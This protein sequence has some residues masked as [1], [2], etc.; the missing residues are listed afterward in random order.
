MKE[1]VEFRIKEE[2]VGLLFTE[3]EGKKLGYDGNIRKIVIDTNDPRFSQIGV[4]QARFKS[5]KFSFFSK[6]RFFFAGWHF[7]RKYSKV[8]LDKATMFR[9]LMTK[10]FEPSGEEC[11][12]IFDES[13]T[14]SICG[15][16]TTQI[17]PLQLRKNS[18]PKSKDFAFTIAINELVISKRAAEL[19]KKNKVTGVTI[20]PILT[21]KRSNEPSSEWFQ[22]IVNN[23]SLESSASTRFGLNP[24]DEDEKGEYRCANG[25]KLGLNILSELR[26]K[27]DSVADFDFVST[28]Q[29]V[30]QRGQGLFRPHRLILVSQKVR[31]II[32]ENNLKG[33]RLE[34]A[35]LE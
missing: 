26:V 16:G 25:H 28:R 35:Y 14:C 1:T 19:F 30:G 18:F 23:T 34:V 24:F 12:T 2:H 4:I 7:E 5:K 32:E 15:S 20:G 31:K 9:F 21:S 3:N 17:G 22:L 10:M 6:A 11:G 8:E 13:T 33:C 29:F 27:K